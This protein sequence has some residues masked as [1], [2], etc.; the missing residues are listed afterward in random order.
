MTDHPS[1]EASL[2]DLKSI[3]RILVRQYSAHPE[4]ISNGFFQSLRALLENQAQS[5]GVDLDDES[6][7]NSWLH[8]SSDPEPEPTP[9][10]LL[11]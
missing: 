3:Y 7:W 2:D 6:E 9:R 11:N 1:L 5:E 10:Q 8:E 4:L